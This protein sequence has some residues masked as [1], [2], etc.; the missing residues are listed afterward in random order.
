MTRAAKIHVV[1]GGRFDGHLDHLLG[2]VDHGEDLALELI[3]LL[4]EVD[5]GVFDLGHPNLPVM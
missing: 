2:L 3:Q 5:V 4:M 1:G